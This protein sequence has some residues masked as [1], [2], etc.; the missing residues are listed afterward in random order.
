MKPHAT[1][2]PKR[3]AKKGTVKVKGFIPL[4]PTLGFDEWGE[5]AGFLP[6]NTITR[7]ALGNHHNRV[8]DNEPPRTR[9]R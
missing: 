5:A 7:N 4:F 6:E 8:R 2:N 3:E 1:S 9:E